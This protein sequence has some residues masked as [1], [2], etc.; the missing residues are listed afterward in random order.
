MAEGRFDLTGRTVV[1]AGAGGGG[2]GTAV[3]S[4]LA[5]AGARIAAIDVDPEKL[6]VTEQ[7]L[8]AAGG[9][10]QWIV[11]DLREPD[12][13]SQAVAT[14]EG[15]LHGLVHVAGGL[16][17]EQWGPI[18]ATAPDTFD[19]IV[20]LNLGSIFLTTRAVGAR[21]VQQ[22]SGGSIVHIASIVGQ[23]SMPYGAGYA[24]AKAGVASLTR[25]AAV[26]LGPAGV[27]VNSVAPGTVRT[28]RNASASPV[29]DAP[30][31][32]AAIPLGRRGLPED[33]AGAVLF[34]LSDLAAFVSGQVLAVDGGS[35]ARSS[36]LDE[37]NLPV[38]VHDPALRARLRE[39]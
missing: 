5:D 2:I 1:V 19:D 13:V 22:G 32:R 12:A 9:A 24:A 25:T 3:C 27:R 33:I 15:T 7:Q 31:E 36:F 11:A 28:A 39:V 20:R 17:L 10:H 30:E 35:S 38:F 6:A 29:E 16:F 21:L 4:V 23:S 14:V 26:E 34:L 8:D 18:V 37:D